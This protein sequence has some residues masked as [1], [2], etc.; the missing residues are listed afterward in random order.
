VQLKQLNQSNLKLN[1]YECLKSG[2]KVCEISF[3]E[4]YEISNL[5]SNFDD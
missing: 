3:G 5:K 1:C 4:R 2:S